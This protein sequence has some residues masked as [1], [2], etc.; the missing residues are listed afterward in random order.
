GDVV[1]KL[2]TLEKA[3]C[4]REFGIPFYVAAPDSTFDP[5]M[6][7]GA[8]IPIEERSEDEVHYQTGI[9]EHGTLRRVRVTSPDSPAVNPAFDL[10]PARFVTGIITPHGILRPG[11]ALPAVEVARVGAAV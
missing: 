10:T 9:D 7:T 6:P 3:I 1:N 2:G 4:A 5:R 11:A 8:G